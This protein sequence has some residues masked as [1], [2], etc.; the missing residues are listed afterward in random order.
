M[1]H[2]TCAYS[3]GESAAFDLS[4]IDFLGWA[5]TATE[6]KLNLKI[7]IYDDIMGDEDEGLTRENI[8][9]W[10]LV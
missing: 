4:R 5:L 1:T 7:P 3:T 2:F 8:L 9:M 10:F 6:M